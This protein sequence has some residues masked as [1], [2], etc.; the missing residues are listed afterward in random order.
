MQ[1]EFSSAALSLLLW[2]LCQD[3]GARQ[4]LPRCL[5]SVVHNG[6]FSL[7]FEHQHIWASFSRSFFS[8]RSSSPIPGVKTPV[9]TLLIPSCLLCQQLPRATAVLCF[10]ALFT[11]SVDSVPRSPLSF[12]D[13]FYFWWRT[14]RGRQ[15][16]HSPPGSWPRRKVM[17]NGGRR[18]D[19]SWAHLSAPII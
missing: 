11:F 10:L 8:R 13:G 5:D 9:T 19:P 6:L 16:S 3:Y 18:A 7:D 1:Q 15:H 17:V 2:L 14:S 4:K 12:G